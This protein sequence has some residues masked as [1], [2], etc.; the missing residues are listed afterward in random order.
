[1]HLTNRTRWVCFGFLPVGL[2]LDC[3]WVPLSW[4]TSY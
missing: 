1:M 2:N 4:T 3:C